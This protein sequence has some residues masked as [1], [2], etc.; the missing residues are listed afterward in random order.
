L[1]VSILELI[2]SVLTVFFVL[3]AAHQKIWAWPVGMAGTLLAIPPYLAAGLVAE[4]FLQGVYTAL[5]AWGWFTWRADRANQKAGAEIPQ[6]MAP[7]ERY[8]SLLLFV[9]LWLASGW[10]FCHSSVLLFLD[11]A[12]LSAGLLATG[13]EAKRKMDAWPL[14][15]VANALSSFVAAERELWAF[16]MLYLALTLLSAYSW[17]KWS[18]SRNSATAETH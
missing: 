17:V 7:R 4:A 14:W 13:L 16:A 8:W 12:L 11:T 9:L 1:T 5:G 3:G 2:S 6:W 10:V 18:R 15:F